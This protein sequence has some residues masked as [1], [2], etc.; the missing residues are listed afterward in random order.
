MGS[1]RAAGVV[2]VCSCLGA[3]AM[4]PAH[5]PI[6]IDV[7]GFMLESNGAVVE[8]TDLTSYCHGCHTEN[9]DLKKGTSGPVAVHTNH[10][11]DVPYPEGNPKYVPV[12]D[13]DPML[14]L[15]AGNLSCITC[16]DPQAAD[17][18]LVIHLEEGELCLAC[19]RN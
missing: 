16:H 6:R 10:P 13:L 1:A 19:H 9:A 18:A 12:A 2:L 7:N 11:V 5:Q 17:R 15:V 4:E 14:R 8:I 3:F